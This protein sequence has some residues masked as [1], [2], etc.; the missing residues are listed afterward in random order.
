MIN[1]DKLFKQLKN[2]KKVQIIYKTINQ[3][4]YTIWLTYKDNTFSIHSFA[5]VGN[6]VLDEDNYQDEQFVTKVNFELLYEYLVDKFPGII[7][8]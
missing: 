8:P 7:Y 5:F 6:T 2:G 1:K 4:Y 3:L